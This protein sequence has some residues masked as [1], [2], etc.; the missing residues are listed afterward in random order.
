MQ[1]NYLAMIALIAT[2]GISAPVY[3]DDAQLIGHASDKNVVI[4]STIE[5]PDGV[6][7][8]PTPERAPL[9]STVSQTGNPL[10]TDPEDMQQDLHYTGRDRDSGYY[11]RRNLP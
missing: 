6:I 11:E 7:N 3:A 5:A 4:Q 1:R 8:I 2:T 9:A 10:D